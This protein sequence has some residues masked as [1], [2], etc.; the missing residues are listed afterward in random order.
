MTVPPPTT[1]RVPRKPKTTIASCGPAFRNSLAKT[2]MMKKIANSPRPI[3]TAF[4]VSIQMEFSLTPETG[5]QIATQFVPRTNV[6]DALLIFRDHYLA[7]LHDRVAIL[8]AHTR[9]TARAS[10]R[11]HDL[12]R[13]AGADRH[14][15]PAQHPDHL[16]IGRVQFPFVLH[17]HAH[18]KPEHDRRAAKSAQRRYQ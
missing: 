9:Y 10:L 2:V 5:F 14:A 18:Q 4:C 8:G 13:A 12:A 1:T 6:G 7:A 3:I 11:E 15:E 16:V 17:Q